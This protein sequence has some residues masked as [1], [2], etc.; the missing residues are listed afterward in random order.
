MKDV[1][2]DIYKRDDG[3]FGYWAVTIKDGRRWDLVDYGNIESI[4][5]LEKAEFLG[6]LSSPASRVIANKIRETLPKVRC[7]CGRAPSDP[8]L[9]CDY[10]NRYND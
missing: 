10:P 2:V 5:D 9:P 6:Q 8:C 4:S 1:E 7:P 3:S